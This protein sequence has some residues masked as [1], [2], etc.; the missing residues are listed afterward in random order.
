MLISNSFSVIWSHFYI[1][2]DNQHTFSTKA[3]IPQIVYS[4][5]NE[6]VNLIA[7]WKTKNI[8]TLKSGT[9]TSQ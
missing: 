9:W 6:E 7:P 5:F 8:L 4:M 2:R 1:P 3:V